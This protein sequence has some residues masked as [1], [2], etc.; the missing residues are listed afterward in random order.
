[1]KSRCKIVTMKQHVFTLLLASCAVGNSYGQA[2]VGIGTSTPH[3]SAILDIHTNARGMLIPRMASAE[4]NAIAGP[5]KGLLLFDNDT[6]SFW[7]YDGT[8]WKELE[9]GNSGWGLTGNAGTNPS[10]HFIGTTDAQPFSFRLDNTYAGKWDPFS[11]NY[12]IGL[13]AGKNT[14]TGSQNIA[15]GSFT[16]GFNTT[17]SYNTAIG[18]R[19]LASNTGGTFNTANGA[20]ALHNNTDGS[21]NIAAGA[22]ALRSNT[23]G[24]YNTAYGYRALYANLIGGFNTAIG[25]FSL[26]SN[27][28][29][30]YNTAIGLSSLNFNTTGNNNTAAGFESL[31]ANSSGASNT[32]YGGAALRA[33]INGSEN[34]ATGALAMFYPTGGSSN[35]ANGYSALSAYSGNANTAVGARADVTSDFLFNATAIGYHARV[36]A[37]MKV[38]I[39]N[40]D[41]GS[42]GGQVSWST[43]SDGRY[44]INVQE[45]VKGL[46]FIKKL[47]PVTY[48]VDV[49]SLKKNLGI[50][51]SLDKFARDNKTPTRQTGF[52]AQE[53][54]A[55]AVALGYS[56][57]G[58]DKPQR[59]EGHYGIRYAEFVVPLV[60]AVQEQQQLIERLQLQVELLEKRLAAIDKN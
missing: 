34:T 28:I 41:V 26:L 44:K 57:S 45:D 27:T 32:A 7:F 56:F 24:G 43:F 3:A 37:S 55:A 19:A 52:I 8:A 1:M 38:R 11:H 46:A 39:G 14:S 31:Y 47:R 4:R 36:D 16:L 53:V 29:G 23:T 2:S 6:S 58:V 18:S 49:K 9:A 42:I 51:D 30:S 40:T 10:T 25:P 33:N 48:I 50:T 22:D 60:K 13:D 59:A 35:T 21:Y 12:F 54:E 5:A 17:G 20:A 15:Y